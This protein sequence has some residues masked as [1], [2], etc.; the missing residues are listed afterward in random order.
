V[1]T[2]EATGGQGETAGQAGEN[3]GNA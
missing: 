3:A 2:T 1:N